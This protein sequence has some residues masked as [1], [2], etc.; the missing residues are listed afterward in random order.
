M[1]ALSMLNYKELL[2]G[3]MFNNEFS[4]SNVNIGKD[5]IDNIQNIGAAQGE[6]EKCLNGLKDAKTPEQRI[7]ASIALM[8][9]QQKLTTLTE[10]FTKTMKAHTDA[11]KAAITNMA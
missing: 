7:E 8:A 6:V 3:K 9:A 10:S 2:G 4:V 1:V 11:Q 5:Y